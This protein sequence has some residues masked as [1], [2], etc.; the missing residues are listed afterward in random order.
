MNSAVIDTAEP[1]YGPH[2]S[3]GGRS[4]TGR[5]W[6]AAGVGVLLLAAA[7]WAVYGGVIEA[8]LICD[9]YTTMAENPSVRKLWP[10]WNFSGEPSPLRPS[11]D[12]PVAA[13]PLVNFTIAINYHFGAMQPAGYRLTNMGIHFAAALVLWGLVRRTLLLEFFAGRFDRA[14]GLLGW[15]S[16]L[17]WAVHP[18]NTEAVAYITQRTE[19]QMGLFYLA[20]MYA[21]VRYWTAAGSGSRAIWLVLAAIACQCGALSKEMM[22]S[23][24]A[25]ALL[26]ERTFISGSFW[27]SLRRSWPLYVALV[28]GWIP[29]VVINYHGP[30][31][32]SAGFHLGLPAYMWWYTQSEVL[33]LYLKLTFWPWPLVLHY[34]IPYK[35]TLAVAWPWVLPVVLLGVATLYLVWR[36]TSAG[37]VAATVVAVLSPTLLVPLVGEIVAERRMYVPL[38]AIVPL[39]VVGAFD[40]VRRMI[41]QPAADAAQNN[42]VYRALWATLG[43]GAVLAVVFIVVANTRLES[44]ADSIRLLED[45][46]KNQPDDFSILVN[47]GVELAK[48]GRPAEAIPFFEH[49]SD[50]YRNAPIL[51]YKLSQESHKLYHNWALACE[52]LN[53]ED[54]AIRHYEEAIEIRPDYALSHYNLGLVLQ[55]YGA[56]EGAHAAIRG[57][58]AGQS[59]LR[60]RTMQYRR[61]IGHGRSVRRGDSVFGSG[62]TARSRPG[63]VREPGRRVLA[64]RAQRGRHP[65]PPRR[66]S[67]W[68]ATATTKIWPGTSSSGCNRTN[69]SRRNPS[70]RGPAPA[71]I[72]A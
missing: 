49:A 5:S 6:L 30:R 16:A 67:A 25:V 9:D 18:L 48:A 60:R 21:A 15:L 47:L 19:S 59:G 58:A 57:S 53:R 4:A 62:R 69:S 38:A 26:Y 56:L 50:L 28:A 17:V 64:S 11:P 40:V 3:A 43:G 44:Y 36:R 65:R 45:T 66:P 42:A 37:F 2:R 61:A 35:E 34:E 24:P 31:T 10:L 51:N 7:V 41:P 68:L 13:R 33:L 20:T 1:G 12:T 23:V 71:G 32:P 52:E 29:Q 27:L 8:P 72:A 63:H 14:A 54:E 22:A 39:V 46:V 55:R 70:E